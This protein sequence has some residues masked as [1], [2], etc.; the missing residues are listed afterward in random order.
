VLGSVL[1]SRWLVGIAPGVDAGV[2][3]VWLAGP[4]VLLGAV[5]LASALP[6]RRAQMVDPLTIMRER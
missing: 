4:L 5:V 3:W 2:I 6:A 1:V